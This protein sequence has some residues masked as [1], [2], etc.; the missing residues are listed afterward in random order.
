MRVKSEVQIVTGT[1]DREAD[2]VIAANHVIV[3]EVDHV[4]DHMKESILVVVVHH[5]IGIAH[6]T[7]AEAHHVIDS[8]GEAEA[9]VIPMIMI[10]IV[11]SVISI[12]MK[13]VKTENH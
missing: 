7:V 11:K 9:G 2:H 4:V 1:G 10:D 13:V 6:V 12:V 3:Q 5:V 8:D